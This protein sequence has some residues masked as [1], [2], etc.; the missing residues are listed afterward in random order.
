[1]TIPTAHTQAAASGATG[2]HTFDEPGTYSYACLIH[3]SMTG[4]VEV[5]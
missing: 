5:G 1:M 2:S 4:T 3:A